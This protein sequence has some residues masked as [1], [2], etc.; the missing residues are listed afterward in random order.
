M[1]EGLIDVAADHAFLRLGWS[2]WAEVIPGRLYRS[3]HPN[4]ARLRRVARRYGIKTV[5]NLR[6]EKP[7]RSSTLSLNAANELGLIHVFAPFESRGAPHRDRILRFYETYRLMQTPA[8]VHC[9]SGADRAGLVSGL[10]ILFERGSAAQARRQLS[11]R[12][13]HFKQSKTGILDEFFLMYA[14]EAEGRKPFLDWVRDEYDE[15]T[16]RAKVRSNK[17]GSFVNEF[18]LRRE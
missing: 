9:K 17:L 13:L 11:L 14:R 18:L 12:F 10:A 6:G 7:N 4:P 3:N 16:L 1:F 2:N 8:L 15:R 5:I